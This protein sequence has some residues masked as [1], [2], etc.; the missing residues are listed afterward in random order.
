MPRPRIGLLPTG[1]RLYWDQFPN[2]KEMGQRMYAG[3]RKQ[4][5]LV[6]RFDSTVDATLVGVTWN[7]RPVGEV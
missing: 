1:N 7:L 5:E 4:L 3:L 2:L 6:W